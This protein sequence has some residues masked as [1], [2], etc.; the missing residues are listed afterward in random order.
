MMQISRACSDRTMTSVSRIL[1]VLVAVAVAVGCSGGNLTGGRGGAGGGG[2]AG[3]AAGRGGSGTSLLC[4]GAGGT[5]VEPDRTQ[6]APT[7]DAQVAKPLVCDTGVPYGQGRTVRTGGCGTYKLWRVQ[8]DGEFFL[9]TDCV[10]ESGG[11]LIATLSCTDTGCTCGGQNVD[12]SSCAVGEDLCAPPDGGAANCGVWLS[13]DPPPEGTTFNCPIDSSCRPT[14]A[15]VEAAD[16]GT[17]DAPFAISVSTGE[18]GSKKYWRELGGLWTKACV[19]AADGAL[20]GSE[21]CSDTGCRYAGQV[22]GAGT[23][24]DAGVTTTVCV[25]L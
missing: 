24:A 18:C 5:V 6:C 2:G 11:A 21:S 9:R 8:R 12:V 16:G 4:N 3:S 14:F 15:D 17:C 13:V 25:S 23:C 1:F 10:Y 19:Y 20:V 22:L 7:Y